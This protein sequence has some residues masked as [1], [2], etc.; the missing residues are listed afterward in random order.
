MAK[1]YADQNGQLTLFA[2]NDTNNNNLHGRAK[3]IMSAMSPV[4]LI[5]DPWT[6][7]SP[8]IDTCAQLLTSVQ[9]SLHV[10]QYITWH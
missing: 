1:V 9:S 3:V 5:I 2:P 10:I 4:Q 8:N 7:D 6:L